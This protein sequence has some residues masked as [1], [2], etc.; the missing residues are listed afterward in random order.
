MSCAKSLTSLGRAGLL[1]LALAALPFVF[2]T[3]HWQTS[4]WAAGVNEANGNN[5][6]SDDGAVGDNDGPNGDNDGAN[7]DVDTGQN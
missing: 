2:D 4:A 5:N 6:D 3:A 1:A 7:G